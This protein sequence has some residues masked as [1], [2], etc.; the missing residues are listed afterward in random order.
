MGAKKKAYFL[1]SDRPAL[2]VAGLSRRDLLVKGSMLGAIITVPTLVV[3]L[4][5]WAVTGELLMPAIAG[6]AVH[7]VAMAFSMKI[8]KRILIKREPEE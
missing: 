1:L 8:A 7:F 5:L 3:F 2:S 4:S 6:A